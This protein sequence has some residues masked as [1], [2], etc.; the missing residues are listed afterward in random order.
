M[1]YYPTPHMSI[2]DTVVIYVYDSL[3]YP[4]LN[5]QRFVHTNLTQ[6]I[7]LQSL[8][9]TDIPNNLYLF[10]VLNPV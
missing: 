6:A 10:Q 3:S 8:T 7:H 2:Y 4:S 9:M 1:W 5:L